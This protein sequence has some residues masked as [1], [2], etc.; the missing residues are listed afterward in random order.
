MKKIL[1]CAL[2]LILLAVGCVIGVL[3]YLTATDSE[4]NV[5][6][7]GDARIVIKEY[8]RV[9]I[10]SGNANAVIQ[11]FKDN[12][13]IRPSVVSNDNFNYASP[14][15]TA[16][17]TD[18]VTWSKEPGGD[19]IIVG[20]ITGDY[21][22]PIWAPSVITNELD[23]MVFVKN[24][25]DCNV[26]VRLCFAFEAGNYVRRARFEEMVH[27]NKNTAD[28]TWTW[29]D[30]LAEID[31]TR[32]FIVWA[33]HKDPVKPGQHTKISLSQIALD[34]SA[35]NDHARA[36]G[37][38]YE[39][40]VFAQGIQSDGFASAEIALA[41][42]FDDTIPF[43]NVK[44]VE[45]V[46]L[47]TALHYLK[48]N[49]SATSFVGSAQVPNTRVSSITFG[50]TADHAEKV[51]GY[52][53]VLVANKATQVDK[54][55]GAVILEADFTAY[56]YY[57]PNSDGQYDIYI[58]ADNW[59]IYTP[60][61][62][63]SSNRLFADMAGVKKIDTTNL[64][65][66]QTRNMKE[67]FNRCKALETIDVS[68]WD[69]SNVTNM[70]YLFSSCN[71]LKSIDV[72]NWDVSN[73]KDMSY[74]FAG[75]KLLTTIGVEDWNVSNVTEM[76]KMF[77]GCSRLTE[78]DLNSWDTGNLTSMPSIFN[79]CG[80]LTTLNISKW[81]VSNV[82]S[83]NQAFYS[84]ENL[85]SVDIAGWD[86]SSVTEMAQMFYGCKKMVGLDLSGWDTKNVTT[87]FG[88]FRDCWALPSL[89]LSQWNTSQVTDMSF[90]FFS[91]KAFT[92]LDLSGWN[93]AKVV[94]S[95]SMFEQCV[96]L[97]TIY[98]GDNWNMNQVKEETVNKDYRSSKNM[99]ANCTALVGAIPY[100]PTK[101]DKTHANTDGYLT[102]K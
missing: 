101:I 99:F 25:G 93:T 43:K 41:E 12:K 70:A 26:Y 88:M 60:N 72:E 84:C 36:F 73:V 45:F 95:E 21:K 76:E 8:E 1:I 96:N 37:E 69:V 15:Y 13:H 67:W 52:D 33:T 83:M 81:D 48:G 94:D 64:N 38:K 87:L 85:T 98:V 65:V 30:K 78:L 58:L 82:T 51:K 16:A 68:D 53:G 7:V 5:M 39:V 55:T 27:L 11:E 34:Y 90:M 22:T 3:A 29:N 23:K 91:C 86:V 28:W 18:Y 40:K 42:G 6:T 62:W 49:T 2:V 44:F 59:E 92:E 97:K 32:C 4:S 89:D 71:A 24:T 9:D 75:C 61:D 46:D 56:A 19:D 77:G 17:P 14:S 100:D 54:N 50:L 80:S 102:K 57:I 63:N 31:G 20:G 47:P 66:S 79:A 10:D 74:T 35:I